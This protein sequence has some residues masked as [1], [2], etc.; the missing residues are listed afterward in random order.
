MMLQ[1]VASPTIVILMTLDVS[2]TL[3]KDIYSGG[4]THI[5]RHMAI[6]IFL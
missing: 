3:L 6:K 2:V 4:I 1:G 5:D